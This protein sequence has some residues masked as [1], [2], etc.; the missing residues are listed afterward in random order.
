MT[1]PPAAP[2]PVH[3]SAVRAPVR[4]WDLPTRLFHWLLVLAVVGL[5]V[6]G[7]LG[8]NWMTWHQ[9]LGYGV[10]ALLLFRLL[11]GVVGGRWSRFAAFVRGPRA[12]W[13]YLRGQGTPADEV[14]H[15]PLGALS[16]L[17]ML[18]MLAVQVGTGLIS[19]DEIA[20]VGP[21]A[22]LV[23]S[24]TAYAATAYHKGWGKA[25]VLT[26]IG[27]HIAAIAL[28]RWRGKAL[29]PAMVHGDKLLPPGTPASADGWPQRLLALGVAALSAAATV[30]IVGWNAL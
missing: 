6:T 18:V 28:Y 12:V 15:T 29:V 3:A 1:T 16:V 10:L 14:G 30:A 2:D 19:D 13:R 11:W 25:L 5:V 23:A 22:H 20:F 8:G 21:L 4:V 24:E 9:R 26:L 27:L 17:A 7:N